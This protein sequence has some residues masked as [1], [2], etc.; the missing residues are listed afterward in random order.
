VIKPRDQQFKN[1][2]SNKHWLSRGLAQH[3]VVKKMMTHD[4]EQAAVAVVISK[5]PSKAVARRSFETGFSLVEVSIVTALMVI[6]AIIG[7][8]ALQAY[9]IESKVPKVAADMQRFVSRMKVAA[10]GGGLAPYASVDQRALINGMRSA[11]VVA[12]QGEG[13]KADVAHGLGGQGRGDNGTITILPE[14]VPGMSV[15][16]AFRLTLTHVNHAACPMLVTAMQRMA[17]VITVAGHG[18]SVQVKNNLIDPP[19]SYQPVLADAQ[20]ARGDNNQFVF[21]FQ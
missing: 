14:A 6:L 12:V 2:I 7:V 16:S 17:S 1:S 9:V 11:S 4:I 13:Q 19:L 10:L 20:C 18:A 15:G 5:M 21:V 8:P 3:G